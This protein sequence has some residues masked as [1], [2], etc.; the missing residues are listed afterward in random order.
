MRRPAEFIEEKFHEGKRL[1]V[2]PTGCHSQC[3][4]LADGSL[5]I[6]A[7]NQT[8]DVTVGHVR[9]PFNPM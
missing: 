7:V 8:P 1:D 4:I 6:A 2:L 3:D 9:I 5:L